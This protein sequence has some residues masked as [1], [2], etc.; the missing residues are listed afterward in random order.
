MGNP[1][2]YLLLSE[3]DYKTVVGVSDKDSELL[4][5]M[6][7]EKIIN[8]HDTALYELYKIKKPW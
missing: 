1:P 4:T 5:I 3:E 8:N 2:K 6:A 7:H